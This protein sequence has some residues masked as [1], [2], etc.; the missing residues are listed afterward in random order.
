MTSWFREP[1]SGLT[2]ALGA[3]LSFFGLMVLVWTAAREGS[4]SHAISFAIFGSSMVLLY[5][6]SAFYH[7]LHA[8]EKTIAF[9]RR[10]DHI[11]IF[12]LIAGTYTP[13]CVHTLHGAWGWSI[14][15]VVWGITA[16]GAILKLFFFEKTKRVSLALYLGMGWL[17]VFAF[18]PLAKALSGEGITW[19]VT[20]GLLYTVGAVFYALEK[21]AAK[22]RL[23]FG[24]HEVF[25]L[26][27][28]AGTASHFWAVVQYVR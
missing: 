11:M 6:A 28:M 3:V 20:G 22:S 25:H 21:N 23:G 26:F 2:H 4:I 1:M 24:A 10:I 27:V 12:V 13:F 18:Y 5:T 14:L 17:V 9:L 16:L 19:V 8:S 7:L 15:G